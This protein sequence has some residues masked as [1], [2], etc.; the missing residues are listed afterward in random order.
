MNNKEHME[1]IKKIGKDPE[2]IKK[3][4]ERA[5]KASKNIWEKDPLFYMKDDKDKS[6]EEQNAEI[7]ALVDFIR[8]MATGKKCRLNWSVK[9]TDCVIV[10]VVTEDKDD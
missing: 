10:K 3:R 6:I 2:V 9:D 5:A 1:H 8:I 4:A 7:L